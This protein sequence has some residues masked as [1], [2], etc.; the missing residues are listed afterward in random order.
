VSVGVILS[1]NNRG[2]QRGTIDVPDSDWSADRKL[3]V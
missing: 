2:A 1:Q 3:K